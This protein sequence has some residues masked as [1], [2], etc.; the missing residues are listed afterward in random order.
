MGEV[1]N[2]DAIGDLIELAGEQF[3]K[4]DFREAARLLRDAASHCDAIAARTKEAE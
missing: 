3:G 2:H 4:A 1:L